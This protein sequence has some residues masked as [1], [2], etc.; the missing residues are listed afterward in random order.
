MNLPSFY[1]KILSTLSKYLEGGLL[2]LG[3]I[4]AFWSSS[5]AMNAFIKASNAAFEVEETR[6][7]ILVRLIV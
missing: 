4:S 6:H 5:A 1:K 2:A 7:F 3:L